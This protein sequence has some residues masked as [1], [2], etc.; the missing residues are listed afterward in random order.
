MEYMIDVD[1][2]RSDLMDYYGTAL[3]GG[4]PMAAL[5]L[6]K[7]ERASDSEIVRIAE[8]N[9]FDLRRYAVS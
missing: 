4:F 9:G 6:A 8:K 1:R 3:A 2:L 5:D 7:I